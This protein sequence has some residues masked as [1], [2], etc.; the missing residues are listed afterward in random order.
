MRGQTMSMIDKALGPAALPAVLAATTLSGTL[1]LSCM[2]P[3]AAIAALCA[4]ALPPRW[5]LAS[6]AACWLGNQ[7]LG[8][9]LM[10]FP[11][12]GPTLAAGFSLLGASRVAHAAARAV[13]GRSANPLSAFLAAFAAYEGVLFA[14]ALGFGDPALFAP[15]IVALV[16]LNEALWFAGLWLGWQVLARLACHALRHQVE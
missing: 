11:W 13:A 9:G 3:F 5:A 2:M 7:A 14:Y 6:I 1:V 12:D 10:G 15:G 16:G 4:L 8:F